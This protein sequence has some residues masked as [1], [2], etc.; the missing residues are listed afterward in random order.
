VLERPAAGEPVWN[1]RFLD[2]ALRVGFDIRLGHPY[3]PQTK[4]RV[5]SGVKYVKQNFWPSARFTDLAD[6]NRQVWAWREHTAEPGVHGTTHAQPAALLREEH[7]HLQ[8]LGL[9]ERFMVFLR[10]DRQVGRD[11]YVAWD[12]NWYGVSWRWARQTVQVAATQDMIEIWA[13]EERLAVHARSWLR[14]KRFPVPGQWAGM[15]LADLPRAKESLATQVP[16][17]EVEH[18]SLSVNEAVVR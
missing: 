18:R 10:E 13:G 3:R 8:P 16:V 2:F 1:P 17:P 15:P 5:E 7:Q 14:G 4:G 6:L 12:A 11:G 9:M